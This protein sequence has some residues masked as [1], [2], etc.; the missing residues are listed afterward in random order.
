MIKSP[1][2]KVRQFSLEHIILERKLYIVLVFKTKTPLTRRNPISYQ[3]LHANYTT[4]TEFLSS[5]TGK[6]LGAPVAGSYFYV[7]FIKLLCCIADLDDQI[8]QARVQ[9]RIQMFSGI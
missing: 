8:N 3:D 2:N 5:E 1:P 6:Y 9:R 7:G 4:F